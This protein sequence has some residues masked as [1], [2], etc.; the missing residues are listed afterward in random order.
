MSLHIY[1]PHRILR[2]LGPMYPVL[3][4]LVI[5]ATANHYLLDAVGGAIV[6]TAAHRFNA[7]LLNLRPIEEWGFWLC[8]TDRPLDKEVFLRMMA[9]HAGEKYK[10]ESQGLLSDTSPRI[11]V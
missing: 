1:S 5:M 2:I 4:L 7:V 8:G 3:I 11:G 9:E 10:E 6:S